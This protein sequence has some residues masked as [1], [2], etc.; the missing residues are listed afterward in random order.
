MA[1]MQMTPSAQVATRGGITPSVKVKSYMVWS[2]MK[3]HMLKYT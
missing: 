1:A 2:N 3:G